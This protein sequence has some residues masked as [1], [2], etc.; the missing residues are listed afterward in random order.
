MNQAERVIRPVRDERAVHRQRLSKSSVLE[1]QVAQELECLIAP[2]TTKSELDDAPEQG[3]IALA[4]AFPEPALGEA[5]HAITVDYPRLG[6]ELCQRPVAVGPQIHEQ[7]ELVGGLVTGLVFDLGKLGDLITILVDNPLVDLDRLS[8][9]AVT[10]KAGRIAQ[11]GLGLL[12][13]VGIELRRPVVGCLTT[14]NASH[15]D[16]AADQD[17]RR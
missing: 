5:V 3:G 11:Q 4:L 14:G 12:A 16:Q 13:G 10:G 6:R 2:G 15:Q 9:L 8:P 7:D 1:R 17:H